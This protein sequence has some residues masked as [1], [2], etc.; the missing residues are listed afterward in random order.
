MPL[1]IDVSNLY[2]L[3]DQRWLWS[4]A[5]DGVLAELAVLLLRM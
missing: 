2:T 3:L 1:Y 5:I 4:G